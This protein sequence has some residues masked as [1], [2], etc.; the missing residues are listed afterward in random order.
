MVRWGIGL[1]HSLCANFKHIV[2]A[3]WFKVFTIFSWSKYQW[4][5][6]NIKNSHDAG[7]VGIWCV[8]LDR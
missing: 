4:I 6:W 2:V 3:V 8:S 5:P 7:I 1:S